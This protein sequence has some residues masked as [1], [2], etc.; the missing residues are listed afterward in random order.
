M[1][2]TGASGAIG[3]EIAA[4]AVRGRLGRRRTRPH[5]GLR[6]EPRCCACATGAPA[7]ALLATP[8]DL[9]QPGA[10][11]A[12]VQAAAELAG[13]AGRPG[14]LRRQRAAGHHR[15]APPH[16]PRPVRK[17]GRSQPGPAAGALPG[18]G[19]PPSGAGRRGGRLHLRCGR[20]AAANQS[21]IAAGR[22]GVIGFCRSLALEWAQLGARLNCISLSFVEETPIFERFMQQAG[23][24]AEA[25]RRRAGLG[26][27]RPADIAPLALFL[28]GPG[29]AKITGQVIS[30]NGG[31]NA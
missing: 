28:C 19:D 25:S 8:A 6:R 13:T 27:P 22:A 1:L 4:Q 7:A 23:G 17:P 2:V 31:L 26:L 16:R 29:A 11:A 12:L 18:G 15:P 14:A 3:F 30:I 20:F 9:M 5:P 21:L 24:R 10:A